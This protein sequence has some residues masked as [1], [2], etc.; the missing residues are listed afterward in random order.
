MK[1]T[2]LVT[3]YITAS[4]S[5]ATA[6]GESA[7]ES[8]GRS[9]T[10]DQ[11]IGIGIGSFAGL[12]V[13]IGVGVFVWRGKRKAAAVTATEVDPPKSP[14]YMPELRAEWTVAAELPSH[15]YMAQE[16]QGDEWRAELKNGMQSC[17]D[18]MGVELEVGRKDTAIND[19][20][21][22]WS[23]WRYCRRSRGRRL[24]KWLRIGVWRPG[25]IRCDQAGGCLSGNQ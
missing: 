1:S 22:P 5:D 23:Y 24:R 6:T 12:T 8:K 9:T 16:L 13:L 3:K 14:E 20:G 15:H 11:S 21:Q 2:A 4:D 18:P 17:F 25:V 10:V 19:W 7:A